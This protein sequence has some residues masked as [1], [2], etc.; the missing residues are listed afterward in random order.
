MVISALAIASLGELHVVLHQHS[1]IA[2][3]DIHLLPFHSD[4][5]CRAHGKTRIITLVF[6]SDPIIHH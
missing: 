3:A 1:L 4:I 5:E 6:A 2:T